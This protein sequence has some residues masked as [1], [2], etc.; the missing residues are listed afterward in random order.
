MCPVNPDIITSSKLNVKPSLKT[1]EPHALKALI[2]EDLKYHPGSMISE[3]KSCLKDAGKK[4]I[5]KAIYL[6]VNEGILCPEG[7]RTYRKYYLAK[8]RVPAAIAAN[9]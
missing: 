3:I 1:I 7:G 8:T 5:Q 4:D 6:L 2:A 9:T